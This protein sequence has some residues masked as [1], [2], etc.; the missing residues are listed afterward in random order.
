MLEPTPPPQSTPAK[1]FD[2]NPELTRFLA[3]LPSEFAQRLTPEELT[4]YAAALSVQRSPHWLDLKASLPIPGFGVY[5]ALMVGRE[6]RSRDRLHREGQLALAPNLLV[7][8]VLTA[9][10]FAG[11]LSAMLLIRGL[12]LLTANGGD[13]WWHAYSA[14]L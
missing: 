2:P 14:F 6:R 11:L 5:V 4:A 8:G 3:R 1:P 12:Q 9:T 10:A 7:A 13:L